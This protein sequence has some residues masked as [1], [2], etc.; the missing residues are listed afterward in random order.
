[1]EFDKIVLLK[2]VFFYLLALFSINILLD[3]KLNKLRNDI[4]LNIN[5]EQFTSTSGKYVSEQEYNEFKDEFPS[6]TGYEYRDS[7]MPHTLPNCDVANLQKGNNTNTVSGYETLSF[8][9][10]SINH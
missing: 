6:L 8:P 2:I 3:I 1:M 7:I 9:F 4:L 5:K 10:M